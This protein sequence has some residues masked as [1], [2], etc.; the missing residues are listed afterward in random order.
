[1]LI[2]GA[3]NYNTCNSR[4]EIVLSSRVGLNIVLINISVCCY[5]AC[6]H[7]RSNNFITLRSYKWRIEF[8]LSHVTNCRYRSV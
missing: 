1:M 2:V 7:V 4:S 8:T 5:T 6:K 3:L